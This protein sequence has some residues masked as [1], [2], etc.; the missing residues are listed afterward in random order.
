MENIFNENL[1]RLRKEKGMT[2]EQLAQAVGVTA[3]AVSKWELTSYPDAGLLPAIADALDVTID[4]L[5]GRGQERATLEQLLT[6]ALAQAERDENGEILYGAAG[7]KR[8]MQRAWQLCHIL[9]CVY[10]RCSNAEEVSRM[11]RAGGC[12]WEA[13][14]QIEDEGGFLQAKL[15]EALPYFLIMPE[16]ERGYDN[17]DA[18]AYQASC[19]ELFRFLGTPNV[20]RA[21]L[22]LAE[23][24]QNVF[25][26][27]G[28]LMEELALERK[29][30]EEII[31]GL[32]KFE[33]VT[34]A[35]L[36]KG[37][38][39]DAIYQYQLGCSLISFLTFARVLLMRPHSY[40]MK[41]QN[42]KSPYCQNSSWK[43]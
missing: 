20:L 31:A 6:E 21:L 13:Y 40:Q 35:E 43:L 14:T 2:Q 1:K 16:P 38:E 18:L 39:K 7:E 41:I 12:D 26:D 8:R 33:F 30:A 42:R 23:Q 3:Q 11:A 36:K 28:T 25:F 4:E 19:A 37:K 15:N 17:P 29:N 10:A 27:C 34:M 22:F 32:L 5:F 24:R 9:A